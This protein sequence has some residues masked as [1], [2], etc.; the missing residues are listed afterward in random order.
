M[1]W[2]LPGADVLFASS[3]WSPRRSWPG[4]LLLACCLLWAPGLAAGATFTVNSTLDATDAVQ[5]DG[6][7]ATS[8]GTCT[9]R[10]AVQEA[11]ALPG[12][13]VISL[14]AGTY[15]L[16]IPGRLETNSATGDL[17][18]NTDMTINGAGAAT[19]IVDAN[20]LD[21]VFRGGGQTGS[22]VMSDLTVQ[23][24]NSGTGNTF[25]GCIY[26]EKGLSLTR[27]VVKNCESGSGGGG[28]AAFGFTATLTDVTITQNISGR[29][30]GGLYMS[31]TTTT[32]TGGTIANNIASSGS[33]G[34]MR[35]VGPTTIIGTTISDNRGGVGGGLAVLGSLTMTD[36]II[37]R[38]VAT[39]DTSG[40]GGGG[41]YFAQAV[42]TLTRTTIS[43]NRAP[44]GGGI[45]ISATTGSATARTVTV[46]ESTITQNVSTVG[47]GGGVYVS[48]PV[49]VSLNLT[50]TISRST[51][52]GNTAS[53][54]GGGIF[55]LGKLVL[56]NT[57]ISGNTATGS[58]GG[59]FRASSASGN[60][61]T[62]TNVTIAQNSSATGGAVDF[63]LSSGTF[64]IA[65]TIIANNAGAAASNCASTGAT[66]L[67]HNVEFPGTS[68]GFSLASDRR[69]DPLLEPLADNFGTTKTH[70]LL[71]GSPAID[72]GDDA[73]CAAAPVSG[74]DQRGKTRPKGAHC[75]AGSFEAPRPSGFTDDPLVSGS[76]TIRA[77]HVA[78][79]RN[80]I[81]ALR[82]A[83]GQSAAS[84]TND[85]IVAT[86]TVI[87]R[88]QMLELRNAL[89]VLGNCTFTDDP[90]PVGAV[91]KAAHVRDVRACVIEYEE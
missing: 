5:G 23:R 33:G 72:L 50:V 54:R 1:G 8:S 77:V 70:A 35:T 20:G 80:R 45:H 18:V 46:M 83:R 73:T 28:I 4:G 14:P 59:A 11:N 2:T 17:N 15:T 91:V 65:N 36:T 43:G 89:S 26:A 21:R 69:A 12:S 62:F 85:P 57:T 84:W 13:D 22:L 19:T 58:S 68:C 63:D 71:P 31:Q 27:V 88:T 3:R 40:T 48:A 66:N 55:S 29:D 75:D 87:T 44:N 90:L 53:H 79:L 74:I 38:N 41:V 82:Q 16:T 56:A 10:A 39:N 25:G 76:S 49:T 37:A 6:A 67:G 32:I 60:V 24:G 42:G 47:D 34:G 52:S 64:S 78:E 30:G 7:C 81:N 51:V 61:V 9:L 86:A